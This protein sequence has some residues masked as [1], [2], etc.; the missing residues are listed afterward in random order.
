MHYLMSY[1]YF[2]AFCVFLAERDAG[3]GSDN[4]EEADGKHQVLDIMYIQF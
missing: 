1:S 4:D 2:N 3:S